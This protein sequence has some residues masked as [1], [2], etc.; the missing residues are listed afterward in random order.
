MALETL[1]EVTQREEAERA[2]AYK[3]GKAKDQAYSA[4]RALESLEAK[5]AVPD[6]DLSS[7]TAVL[8]AARLMPSN[9]V[10]R[11]NEFLP[12]GRDLKGLIIA[13]TEGVIG[14]VA[15][16]RKELEDALPA[17]RKRAADA[18]ARLA[19]FEETR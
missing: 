15:T 3:Y 8:E 4:N 17:A 11:G 12:G 5:L 14:V 13:E 7:L 2:R 9:I 10:T 1:K 16:K 6:P 19:E 18:N